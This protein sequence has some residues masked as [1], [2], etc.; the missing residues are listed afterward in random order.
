[1]KKTVLTILIMTF[2][3]V[4]FAENKNID[5]RTDGVSGGGDIVYTKP[6]KAVIFSHKLHVEERGL[7]CD[8][9]HNGLFE[10]AALKAQEK[11]DFNMDSLYKGKY[12]GA[13]HDGKMAFASN[14]QCARCHTGV[15]GYNAYRK[16]NPVKSPISGPKADIVYTSKGIGPAKFSH[17]FHAKAF[18]CNDCHAKHFAM[19]K[20]G[21]NMKMDAMYGGKFCG[22]CHNGST[23]SAVTD[24]AK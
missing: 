6:V 9:C 20:G 24:C 8:M 2:V 12:C 10:P 15:K 19:K 21:S 3:T 18:G 5:A 7:S 1:M 23:A 17:N 14:T 4:F 13:C 16:M 22:T 11:G